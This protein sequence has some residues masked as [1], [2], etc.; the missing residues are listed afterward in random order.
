MFQHN[1]KS[2][3]ISS[4]LTSWMYPIS[5]PETSGFLV[6][7]PERLW[8]NGQPKYNTPLKSNLHCIGSCSKYLASKIFVSR[9]LSTHHFYSLLFSLF[10]FRLNSS[11]RNKTGTHRA[12]VAQLV[13]NRAAM[14]EAMSSIPAGPTLNN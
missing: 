12:P 8:D 5:Y 1:M 4:S 11:M 6:S 7:H 2:A 9:T 13:E 3:D 14:R 10:C